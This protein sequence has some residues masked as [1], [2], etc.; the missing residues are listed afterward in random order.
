MPAHPATLLWWAQ[1]EQCYCCA[2]L[3]LREGDRSEGIMTCR[4]A[5][6]EP[7][8]ID[9]RLPGEPCGP[10]GALFEERKHDTA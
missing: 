5:P 7:Y 8:C 6:A 4:A 10:A 9:A 3:R 2:H 1:R